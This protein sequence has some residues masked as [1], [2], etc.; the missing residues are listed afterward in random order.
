MAVTRV[1]PFCKP[2]TRPSAVTVAIL[3]SALLQWTA[4]LALEEVALT[5]S[6]SEATAVARNQ[7]SICHIS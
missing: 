4:A 3:L 1:V 6:C 7:T 5:V 2:E